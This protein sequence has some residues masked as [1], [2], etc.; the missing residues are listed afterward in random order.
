MFP[1]GFMFRISDTSGG[2]DVQYDRTRAEIKK[3]NNLSSKRNT[4]QCINVIKIPTLRK[5][6]AMI[7]VL[8][9]SFF[10]ALNNLN[11]T[12]ISVKISNERKRAI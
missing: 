4:Y 12:R 2:L 6:D 5:H 11:Y 1:K 9:E 3:V 10:N 8:I 7:T